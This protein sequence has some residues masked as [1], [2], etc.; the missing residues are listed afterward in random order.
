MA[1][2]ASCVALFTVA[3]HRPTR[4]LLPVAALY[5]AAVPIYTVLRPGDE[6][7][8][9]NVTLGVFFIVLLI[10]WGMFVRARRQ[11]VYSLRD[12]AQRAE[13]EQEL[14]IAQARRMERDRIAREMHDVLAHRI[15]LVSL[16]A[17]ALEYSGASSP[18]E[19]A[20][21]AGVIRGARTSGARR[22][23]RGH[24][25]AARGR[26][27]GR[28]ARAS[29]AH[30]RRPRHAR[31]RSRA[32]AGMRV[33][34]E[35]ALA[36]GV[37]TSV[38]RNAYRV[39]QEG[40]TNARKHAP[41]CAVDVAVAGAPG[42]GA[43]DRG[44]QPAARRGARRP[45]P[46][47][48]HGHRRADRAGRAGGRAPGA[49]PARGRVAPL[50]LAPLAGVVTPIRVL[51]VDDDALVRAGLSMILDATEDVRVVAEVADGSE[52]LPAVDAYAPDVV[53]MDIRMPRMDGLAATEAL[54]ARDTAPEIIVLTTFDADEYVLR[55]LRSGAS[56]FL[57]KDT[58]PADIVQAIRLVVAGEAMLSPGV[59]RRLIGHVAE[60]GGRVA[61]RRTRRSCSAGSPTASARSPWRSGAA[62][63]TRRSP[64]SCS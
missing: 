51:I 52:V 56:G 8:W 7:F 60:T 27:A 20:R 40:L 47:C 44:A 22:P 37:P 3:V 10:A 14:R 38:G 23:A 46:G 59:T 35:L 12:R 54:T 61:A 63:R 34:G 57:L 18:D 58:P 6:N 41:D 39:V 29:A 11:L 28:R 33:H 4:T 42:D 31:W 13:A 36:E 55:A 62:A 32:T 64:R 43:D 45:D 24:R 9:L 26:R 1:S 2:I 50:G 16:H 49:R 19:V 15:S 48:G 21:A 30:D 25:G 5:L 53:L 17:G